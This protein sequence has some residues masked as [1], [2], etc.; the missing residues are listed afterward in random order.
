M[1]NDCAIFL[2]Y[3]GDHYKVVLS[4]KDQPASTLSRSIVS[5][6]LPLSVPFNVSL[7]SCS[8]A[9]FISSVS[10]ISVTKQYVP[11]ISKVII[12]NVLASAVSL[13]IRN[14][15]SMTALSD[16]QPGS[17]VLPVQHPSVQNILVPATIS[18]TIPVA[19]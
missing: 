13:S 19:R 14:L 17:T 3:N 18:K 12:P 15:A 6:H 1:R 4:V 16:S 11:A 8:S 5:T 7:P 10:A 9:S 2:D